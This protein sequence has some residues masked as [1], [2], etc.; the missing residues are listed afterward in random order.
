VV[1]VKMMKIYQ[2]AKLFSKA[3]E[4]DACYDIYAN[5]GDKAIKKDILFISP[6]DI[7]LVGTGIK[8][9]IP[10]GYEGVIRPRSGMSANTTLRIANTPGTID[11]GYRDE[12]KI[13]LHNIGDTEESINHD[14]R[15]AQIAF[16]KVPDI[17]VIEVFDEVD[18]GN[19]DR[20]AKGFG[21]TGN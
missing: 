20:G 2:N 11:A 19:S 18:L 5:L 3:H 4:T 14:D 12:V 7:E 8:M 1:K 21:S 17:E 15:I 13:I 16:R 10:V 6:G 9:S